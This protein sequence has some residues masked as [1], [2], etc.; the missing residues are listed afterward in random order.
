MNRTVTNECSTKTAHFTGP[1]I[2]QSAQHTADIDRRLV[3]RAKRG[4]KQAFAELFER[5]HG[6][7]SRL[8]LHMIRDPAEVED[9]SQEVFIKAYLGLPAFRGDSAFYSWL[10]RIGVNAAKNHLAASKR[11]AP[12]L[13]GLDIEQVE[14]YEN[15]LQLQDPGTPLNMLR[16]GEMA[17]ALECAAAELSPE[18]RVALELCEVRAMSYEDIARSEDCPIGTVRSRI[19]RAREAIANRL[20]PMLDSESDRIW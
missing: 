19:F 11:R 17:Q 3:A 2:L 9:L 10:Y 14:S 12:T 18:L 16:A 8:L 6:R 20:R 7:L 5:H 13:T 4:D 15:A 1:A